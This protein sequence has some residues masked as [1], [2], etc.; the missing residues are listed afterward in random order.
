MKKTS[1]KKQRIPEPRK[2]SVPPS[3]YQPTKAEYEE[4]MDM[5]NLSLEEM[6][7]ALRG[8]FRF[9]HD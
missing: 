8:P 5:P 6:R 4:E 1:K 7:K 9:V 2:L 3:N